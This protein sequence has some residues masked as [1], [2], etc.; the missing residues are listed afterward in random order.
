MVHLSRWFP[1]GVNRL[2]LMSRIQG[3]SRKMNFMFAPEWQPDPVFQMHM[4]RKRNAQFYRLWAN[5]FAPTGV[6][7]IY[8]KISKPWS[9][10]FLS[11]LLQPE[12]F[13]WYKS[14]LSSEIPPTLL[15][16]EL[17]SLSFAI[18]K[19]CLLET[20]SQML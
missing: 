6:P 20:C 5:Y 16:P 1:M 8:V 10:F 9:S 7:E 2:W 13:S 4:S 12:S 15:E 17:E 18:P 3:I 14:F 11:N 19:T